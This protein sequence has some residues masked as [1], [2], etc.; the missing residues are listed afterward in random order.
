MSLKVKPQAPPGSPRECHDPRSEGADRAELQK[1]AFAAF[2]RDLPALLS[3]QAGKWVAYHGDRR[4]ALGRSNRDLYR[5]CSRDG[6][7]K[8]EF[9][10]RRIEPEPPEDF[11]WEE[12]RDI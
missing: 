11:D 5:R 4:V 2:S 1:T 8:D 12:F 10:V 3:E 6:L 7:P 9:V